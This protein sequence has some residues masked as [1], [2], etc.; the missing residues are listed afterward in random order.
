MKKEHS[1]G[2][3]AQMVF[4]LSHKQ[5]E[6]NGEA[7]CL[8]LA[9]NLCKTFFVSGGAL[10]SEKYL[11]DDCVVFERLHIEKLYIKHHLHNHGLFDNLQSWLVRSILA[12]SITNK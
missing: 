5:S 7:L 9:R 8:R 2:L 10:L 4:P 1:L 3:V 6:S 11:R 12:C